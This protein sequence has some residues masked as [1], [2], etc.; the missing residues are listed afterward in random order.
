MLHSKRAAAAKHTANQ[1]DAASGAADPGKLRAL[2]GSLL[3]Q[4]DSGNAEASEFQPAG[5]QRRGQRHE[6]DAEHHVADQL[7]PSHH[8]ALQHAQERETA[9]NQLL[10]ESL[11]AKDGKQADRL[12][13]GES[14][15][16]GDSGFEAASAAQQR[17]LAEHAD[18]HAGNAFGQQRQDGHAARQQHLQQ[19]HDAKYAQHLT[20]MQHAPPA[21]TQHQASCVV[22]YGLLSPGYIVLS[23]MQCAT[24]TCKASTSTGAAHNLPGP[25]A[26]NRWTQAAQPG[27][28]SPGSSGRGCCSGRRASARPTTSSR[29]R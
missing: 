9:Q 7:Q 5:L 23:R 19:R 1:R 8:L 2:N 28:R 11:K 14:H 6:A 24:S 16:T 26:A 20:R 15:G 25:S 21:N 13:A 12:H 3:S 4:A 18:E 29:R 27:R 10:L 22:C 17:R